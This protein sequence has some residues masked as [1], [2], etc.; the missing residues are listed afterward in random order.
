MEAARPRLRV[1]FDGITQS[2]HLR[3]Q[4]RKILYDQW[5]AIL[6]KDKVVGIWECNRESEVTG[7]TCSAW[8]APKLKCSLSMPQAKFAFI[9]SQSSLDQ[10][11]VGS[12]SKGSDGSTLDFEELL[13]CVARCGVDKYKPVREMSGPTLALAAL[14]MAALTLAALTM[15]ALTMATHSPWLYTY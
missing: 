4:E 14:T 7:D 13:E 1:W 5:Q 10:Q 8:G 6:K 11:S 2:M 3:G 9:N 12:S 15:T